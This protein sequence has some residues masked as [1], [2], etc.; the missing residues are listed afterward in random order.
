MSTELLVCLLSTVPRGLGAL[1]VSVGLFRVGVAGIVTVVPRGLGA[2]LCVVAIMVTVVSRGLG[3]LL[4]VIVVAGIG[5]VVPRGLG[6]LL[7]VIVV[8]GMV[9]AVPG[10]LVTLRVV[11]AEVASA[12]PSLR[13]D[14]SAHGRRQSSAE[15]SSL[16]WF[17]FVDLGGANR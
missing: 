2:L 10:G 11:F 4:R 8:A 5:T 14:G 17:R 15:K 12:F 6:T 7:R 16:P 3:T 9:T 1:G 13:D